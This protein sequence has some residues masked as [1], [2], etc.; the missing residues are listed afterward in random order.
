MAR[1]NYAEVVDAMADKYGVP[2]P[3]VRAIYEIETSSG[4][5]AGTSSAG[6]RGQMQLMPATAKEMGVRDIDDPIQN[7]EGGVRYYARML[8]EFR[9]PVLAA[10]AYNAGPGRVKNAGGVP[11]IRETQN[12]VRKFVDMVGAPNLM[13]K[14]PA[15]TDE[16]D[17]TKLVTEK[18]KPVAAAP[19]D[20][21]I[22]A[23][24]ARQFATLLAGIGAP[25]RRKGQPAIAGI[26]AGI[27]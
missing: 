19:V 4:R 1:R 12:Y 17:V 25:K 14:T 13:D 23:E 11:R 3:F 18:P 6:A 16:I 24:T 26:L 20:I 27:G 21:D 5:N 22:E 10:A 9:D 7:I 15:P 8:R 2:R